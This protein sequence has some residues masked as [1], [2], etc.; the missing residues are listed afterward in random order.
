MLELR[1]CRPV[2]GAGR[3]LAGGGRLAPPV[4]VDRDALGDRV[5]PRAQVAPVLEAAVGA[6][7]AQERLLERVLRLRPSET[8][9]QEGENL[10]AQ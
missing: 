10:A 2:V 6:Q 5:R 4:D 9:A 8:P 7:R 3:L 1:V